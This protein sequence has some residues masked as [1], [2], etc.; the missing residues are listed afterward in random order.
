MATITQKKPPDSL[1]INDIGNNIANNI[2]NN[3]AN[4]NE[5]INNNSDRTC[6][7]CGKE[8][9]YPYQFERHKSSIRKCKK[10]MD[11]FVCNYC[12]SPYSSKYNLER[13]YQSC[14]TKK[15]SNPDNSETIKTISSTLSKLIK[16][17]KDNIHKD[18][19]KELS[20]CLETLVS[21][22]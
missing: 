15:E 8:F 13:H 11:D 3:N 14:K 12:N 9:E 5:N 7:N 1:H 16:K 19:I 20:N 4:N 6:G 21:D 2:A 17:N 22:I 10:K 18:S